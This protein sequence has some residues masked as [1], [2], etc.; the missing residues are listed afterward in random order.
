MHSIGIIGISNTSP[1]TPTPGFVD[2]YL[3]GRV[4]E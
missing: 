2:N 4:L 3:Y 1:P